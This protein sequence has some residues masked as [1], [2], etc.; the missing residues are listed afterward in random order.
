MI[1]TLELKNISK[2]IK[3]TVILNDINLSVKTGV[4]K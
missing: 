1:K 3:D 2:V 4:G